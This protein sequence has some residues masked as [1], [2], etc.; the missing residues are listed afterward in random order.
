MSA[1]TAARGEAAL[2]L[3]LAA[4]TTV[5]AAAA[6]PSGRLLGTATASRACAIPLT[7]P[8]GAATALTHQ[9]S[10]A[11]GVRSPV[12]TG[13]SRGLLGGAVRCDGV[14]VTA[15]RAG[16]FCA[17][18]SSFSTST[19]SGGASSSPGAGGGARGGG[20]GGRRGVRALLGMAAVAAGC[21]GAWATLASTASAA[22]PQGP[23]AAASVPAGAP[24]PAKTPKAAEAG[25][26]GGGG[27]QEERLEEIVGE[28]VG[29]E[30]DKGPTEHGWGRLSLWMP[31]HSHRP[32]P[33]S[34]DPNKKEDDFGLPVLPAGKS[35]APAV[36]PPTNRRHPAHLVAQLTTTTE[37]LP[38]SQLHKYTF[39]TYDGRV[40]GPMIRARVGDVLELQYVN[41]DRDGV[42]HN[43]DLH[44]VTGPG[45]G[46]PL[47]FAEEGE[48]KVATFRLLH[49]GLF[50][51][52][53]AAAPVPTHMANGMYGLVLVEPAEGLPHV[54]REFY[55]MQS[56]IY[57][58]ESETKGMLEYS[59]TDGLAESPR[60]VVFNGAEGSLTER[61]P[62]VAEQGERVRIYFGNA[63]PNL[64]S[65][66]HVIGGIFDKVYREGDLRSPP[67]RS[68]QTTLVPAGGATVVE[69][70]LPVAGNLTLLD[71]SIFRMEKGAV[72]F[73][74]VRPKGP[75][76]RRDIYDSADPP[77]N[78]PG[79]K[80]HN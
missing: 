38:C 63:G 54:D 33:Y 48:T 74:K 59:Y 25:R 55:V 57:G 9:L 60:L 8:R 11:A 49:P 2:R 61:S 21:G 50:I 76:R 20:D 40:P 32:H 19:G 24:G 26:G 39:W 36:P 16:S 67:G 70:D 14:R 28:G 58:V 66:F 77:V 3:V 23:A 34:R 71:H 72:G 80:L 78:C 45:G 13:V 52:H 7:G 69:L 27:G 68:I 42:G 30:V 46:A 44:C 37:D 53:C 51:Y 4:S 17:P 62:L 64:I 35:F 56:E 79:C 12:A 41:Q 15:S 65:S 75:D 22:P 1:A 47:L 29:E 5:L 6:A 73:L 10:T 43:I 31:R 18:A